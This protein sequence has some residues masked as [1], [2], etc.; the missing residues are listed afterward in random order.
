MKNNTY[1]KR[2][3]FSY[4]PILFLTISILISIFVTVINELNVRNAIQ[5][6]KVT[7]G[8]IS[9]MIDNSLKTIDADARKV[10][11]TNA[12]LQAFLDTPS[13]RLLSYAASNILSE[14]M[15]QH[16]FIDSIY[17]YR[18]KDKQVLDQ[19][20]I[21]SIDEF[22]DRDY[23]NALLKQPYP[24]NWSSPRVK[25]GSNRTNLKVITL[26]R[27]VPLDTGSLGYMIINVNL[28]AIS[29]FTDGMI[30]RTVTNAQI[31][32]ADH[33]PFFP[34]VLFD[35]KDKGVHAAVTSDY[36]GWTYQTGIKG[37]QLYSI[38]LHG[39]LVWIVAVL[40]A[41]ALAIGSTF[42]VTRRSYRPIEAILHRIDRF[43]NSVISNDLKN[44]RNE[45]AFIDLAI[46]RLITNNMAFQERQVEHLAIRRQQF[47]QNL[48]NG[49][50]AEDQEVWKLES[51]HFGLK[52]DTHFIVALLEIDHY[53]QFCMKYNQKDQSLFKFVIS[54]VAVEF[55][56]QNQQQV[57]MEWVSKNRLVLLQI[58]HEDQDLEHH[59]LKMTE[60]IRSWIEAHLDFTV[61]FGV[62][63]VAEDVAL[64]R[65]SYQ[66]A[67]QAV[68]RK[69]TLGINQII[70]TVEGNEKISD[71]W[72]TYL[73]LIQSVV[74][75]VRLADQGWSDAFSKL[76]HE[77]RVQQLQRGD[78]ERLL[79]YFIFQTERELEGTQT[80][81]DTYW[82]TSLKSELIQGLEHSETLEQIESC[83]RVALEKMLEQLLELSQNRRH[84]ALMK[85]IRSFVAENFT[86]SNL[87]L[88]LL[89]DRFQVN[90]KYLSQ[91]FK[92]EL[93]EN[94]SDFLIALRMELAKKLL[95][96]TMETVQDISVRAGYTNSISFSRIFK[97]CVGLS[98]G[99]YR[100][101]QQ[102]TS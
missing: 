83:Y 41:I 70:G 100:E 44:D 10:I 53:V 11:Q 61:T 22:P 3:M 88:T 74:R 96:E 32:D 93:G 38:L 20:T 60:Q 68:N 102:L 8:Y 52:N 27:K 28:D 19:S 97:K 16:N 7:T 39:N 57:I 14:M 73:Q 9:N 6:N 33:Q 66:E 2:M 4:L 65:R 62:G 72:F 91:L 50:Y 58:S 35:S 43:S 51:E 23:I 45:F 85:E 12:E 99:Q 34:N 80:E 84:H 21:R 46:E 13:D 87:S 48:L 40:G 79:Q 89:S 59:L 56:E 1:I 92:E 55:S 5:A 76:F 24:V 36:T 25:D 47:L 101:S 63:T 75:Q 69:V 82:K 64:I 71:E 86:D 31:Y 17:F 95:T 81:I 98:P 37:S 54:S 42:Y 49:E 67:G 18:A 77:I 30:D 90:S 29:K 15:V 78:I 94:F 26:G